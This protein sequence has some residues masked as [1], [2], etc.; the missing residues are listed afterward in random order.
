MTTGPNGMT[1][2]SAWEAIVLAAGSGSR[3]GGGKL[4]APIG[5]QPLIH[6][7]LAAAFAAPVRRVHLVVGADPRVGPAAADWG[8]AQ[9]LTARLNIITA[10]DHAQGMGASLR[11]GA[12]AIPTDAAGVFVFLGDMPN[13][14]REVLGELARAVETGAAAA[15]PVFE[16][17]RGHPVLFAR[18]LVADLARRDGDSGARDLLAG[19][20]PRLAHVVTNDGGVLF[21]IDTPAALE[22]ARFRPA[23]S[24]DD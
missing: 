14:P 3:F 5:Q 7:A 6:A 19:L 18:G 9:G 13:I 2:T 16:G 12:Q 17:R 10:H 8:V 1:R 4:M 22:R 24:A 11:A 21:D 15:A 20:G 23:P